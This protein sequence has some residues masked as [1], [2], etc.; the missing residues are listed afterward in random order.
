M[1]SRLGPARARQQQCSDGVRRA[2][3]GVSLYAQRGPTCRGW[4]SARRPA[5]A[6]A[7]PSPGGSPCLPSS[8]AWVVVRGQPSSSS[9]CDSRCSP[10]TDR[11]AP[12]AVGHAHRPSPAR[13]HPTTELHDASWRS[14]DGPR[15]AESNSVGPFGRQRV[16]DPLRDE[17]ALELPEQLATTAMA[18]P[19]GVVM[20][21]PRSRATSAQPMRRL[22]SSGS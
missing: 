21:N 5:R 18:E 13:R 9:G 10:A 14:V 6:L 17:S 15:S 7:T 3:C 2:G 19:I 4:G 8:T 11:R 16:A 20:S 12:C 1:E 22:R